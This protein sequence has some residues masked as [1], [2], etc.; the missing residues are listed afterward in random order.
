MPSVKHLVVSLKLNIAASAL[1]QVQV[2][3]VATTT[4]VH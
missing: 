2:A 1:K 3:A 4:V